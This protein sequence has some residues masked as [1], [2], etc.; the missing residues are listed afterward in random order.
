MA[1]HAYGGH[2]PD[3]PDFASALDELPLWSA[4]FGLRLLELVTLRRDVTALDIG[5]GTGFPAIELADRLGATST[6]HAIEPWPEGASRIRQKLAVRGV[7]NVVVHV[8]AAER[9]PVSDRSVDLVVSNNGFNNVHDLDAAFRECAR[10]ARPGA[11]MAFSWNLPETMRELY[12]VLA[13]VL[14]RAIGSE[15]DAARRVADHIF[16][17][18]KPLGYM[19][20]HVEAAGFTVAQVVEDEFTLSFTD[21]TTMFDHFLMRSGFVGPWL[22]LVDEGRRAAVFSEVEDRLNLL[23]ARAGG[24]RLSIPFACLDCRRRE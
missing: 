7:A 19:R 10:V 23:A 11:Q 17:K 5:S 24:L 14:G 2:D 9:L 3:H 18:R 6:V 4:P 1:R 22:E 12:G 13:P 16:E 21:G 20:E 8:A 15:P